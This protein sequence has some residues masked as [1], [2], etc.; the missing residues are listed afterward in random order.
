MAVL[1]IYDAQDHFLKMFLSNILSVYSQP[2]F[3]SFSIW[4]VLGNKKSLKKIVQETHL[5]P[6]TDKKTSIFSRCRKKKKVMPDSL[7]T[8]DLC[9][10]LH[11]FL[12]EWQ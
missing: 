11:F 7:R 4:K 6:P 12:R 8:T 3:C 1:K 5:P 2:L 9:V 10:G